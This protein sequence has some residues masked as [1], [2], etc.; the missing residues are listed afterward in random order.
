MLGLQNEENSLGGFMAPKRALSITSQVQ[1][2][3]KREFAKEAQNKNSEIFVMY[4][5][6]LEAT[7]KVGILIS[8]F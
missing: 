4:I 7:D 5:A 6:A 1:L 3:G 8:P 2:I